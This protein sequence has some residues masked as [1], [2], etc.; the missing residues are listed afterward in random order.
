MSKLK[1]L[2]HF[3]FAASLISGAANAQAPTL[4]MIVDNNLR[5]LSRGMMCNYVF[6]SARNIQVDA[7][8]LSQ[9]MSLI[10]ARYDYRCGDSTYSDTVYLAFSNGSRTCHAYAFDGKRCSM[11][12]RV[13]AR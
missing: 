12:G 7:Y 2:I 13:V 1:G 10:S 5:D 3:A 8:D 4:Y 9:S 6:G 11:D